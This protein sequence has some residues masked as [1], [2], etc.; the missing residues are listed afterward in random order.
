[1]KHGLHLIKKMIEIIL[2]DDK[3][4]KYFKKAFVYD[5]N[6]PIYLY[7]LYNKFHLFNNINTTYVNWNTQEVNGKKH[8]KLYDDIDKRLLKELSNYNILFARKFTG[9]PNIYNKI[10]NIF[11]RDIFI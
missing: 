7:S 5:E 6:Y 1:M 11:Y 3:Y 4:Y 2:D 8:P 9:N 10:V